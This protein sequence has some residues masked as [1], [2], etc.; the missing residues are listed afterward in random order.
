M[1]GVVTQT[2]E[3]AADAAAHPKR[4]KGRE[5]AALSFLTIYVDLFRF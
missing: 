5:T 2:V 3:D 1:Q 4:T